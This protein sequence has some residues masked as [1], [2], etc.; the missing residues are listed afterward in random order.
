MKGNM[1]QASKKNSIFYV[2][3]YYSLRTPDKKISNVCTEA[4]PPFFFLV[5]HSYPTYLIQSKP[6]LVR[7]SALKVYVYHNAKAATA[8]ASP[9]SPFPAPK[10]LAA[11][12]VGE[13]LAALPD[14]V[15]LGEVA[16]AEAEDA[17]ELAALVAEGPAEEEDSEEES[18]LERV[19]PATMSGA[20][21]LVVPEAA[22]A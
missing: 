16:A 21:L 12:P 2:S 9:T 22:L 7:P 14:A 3:Y 15:P 6:F 1:G 13:A 19:P 4:F 10:F 17:A 11:A 5:L 18:D 20:P 8:T